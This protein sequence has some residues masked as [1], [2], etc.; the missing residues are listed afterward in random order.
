MLRVLLEDHS[1]NLSLM[2]Q[3]SGKV[4]SFES[5]GVMRDT[6]GALVRIAPAGESIVAAT[7]SADRRTVFSVT[8]AGVVYRYS[9]S[10]IKP[11]AETGGDVMPIALELSEQE[12]T[13]FVIGKSDLVALSSDS[14]D[15]LVVISTRPGKPPFR[16]AVAVDNAVV[17]ADLD[18]RLERISIPDTDALLDELQANSPRE[19]NDIDRRHF[20]IS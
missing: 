11:V 3:D 8:G 6:E 18:G 5:N 12:R 7:A 14:G 2:V 9:D 17:L 15:P 19:L 10:S 1:L 4:T 20:R 13:L 16:D